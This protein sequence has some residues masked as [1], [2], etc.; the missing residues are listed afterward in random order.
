MRRFERIFTEIFSNGKY[1]LLKQK[2]AGELN[3]ICARLLLHPGA[4]L[5]GEN[6]RTSSGKELNFLSHF[7]GWVPEDMPGVFL[8][9]IVVREMAAAFARRENSKNVIDAH[10]DEA[11]HW[12]R[13][14]QMENL[15]QKNPLILSRGE[16][17]FLWLLLQ[18]AKEPEYLI[19][20]QIP[21]CFSRERRKIFFELLNNFPRWG[22]EKTSVILGIS[23]AGERN[24]VLKNTPNLEW[25]MVKSIADEKLNI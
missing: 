6:S 8:E 25:K 4:I 21:H 12:L 10:L 13:V 14:F 23:T 20:G 16:R 9:D 24:E 11:L 17:V 15:A 7:I 18:V 2:V 22:G 19:L 3:E 1:F 5:S